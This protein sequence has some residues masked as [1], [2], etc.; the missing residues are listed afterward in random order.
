MRFAQKVNENPPLSRRTQ[1]G[2]PGRGAGGEGGI[3]PLAPHA[4]AG[5]LSHENAF[6]PQSWGPGG[7]IFPPG[8][9]IR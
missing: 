5:T 2:N 1:F 6:L 8:T 9:A 4:P 7:G 3:F